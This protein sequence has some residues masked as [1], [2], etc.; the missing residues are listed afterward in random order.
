VLQSPA[1]T[2]PLPQPPSSSWKPTDRGPVVTEIPGAV[3]PKN[4][5][6]LLNPMEEKPTPKDLP[7]PEPPAFTSTIP[8]F[9]VVY[10]S[11]HAGEQPLA[12]G[13]NWLKDNGYRTVVFLRAAGE[14]DSG[15]RA[16]VEAK[17]LKY[18]SLEVGPKTLSRELVAEFGKIVK[19]TRGHP[20]FV[21]DKKGMPAGA[22]WY[23]H[24]RLNDN[25]TDADARGRATR[26]GLKTDESGDH[27]ELWLAINKLLGS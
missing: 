15:A 22:M 7:P 10:D 13:F 2:A 8:R 24:F 25:A 12:D 11:V 16:E 20:L 26:L 19:D 23:L 3:E 4:G 5:A 9:N 1:T 14:D 6:K 27:A 18:L 17:G 21:Y